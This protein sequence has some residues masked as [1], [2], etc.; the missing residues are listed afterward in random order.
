MFYL[1]ETFASIALDVFL[2]LPQQASRFFLEVRRTRSRVD[3]SVVSLGSCQ[4]AFLYLH[5]VLLLILR[6][7]LV[8][9]SYSNPFIN[10]SS[11]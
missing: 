4:I 10:S 3:L 5:I 1:T 2:F 6:R 8:F 7:S 9:I 11:F